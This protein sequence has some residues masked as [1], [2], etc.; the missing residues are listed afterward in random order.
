MWERKE[1]KANAK[2]NFMCNYWMCVVAGLIMTFCISGGSG[3]TGFRS[4]GSLT[5]KSDFEGIGK[6]GF[7][8]EPAVLLAMVGMILLVVG[9]AMLSGLVF[10]VFLLQPLEVG[11]CR[12]YL[13]NH[14]GP[15][16]IGAVAFAFQ[17]SYFNILKTQFFKVLFLTLWG[18]LAFV[19]ELIVGIAAIEAFTNPLALAGMG[20]F[21]CLFLIPMIIKSYSYR[22]VSFILADDPDMAPMEVLKLSKELMDGQK[23]RAFVLDLSFLGWDLLAALTLELLSIFFVNPYRYSAWAELYLCIRYHVAEGG[24]RAA[25]GDGGSTGEPVH[26]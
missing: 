15:A 17:H 16:K 9:L 12:F 8:F 26:P 19:P 11:C 5:N 14:N 2:A 1:L 13:D 22:L 21:S 23:F 7:D 4:F 20:F 18:L 24:Q 25:G 3:I 6:S 10:S